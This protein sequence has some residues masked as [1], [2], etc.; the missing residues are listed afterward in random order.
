[1][2]HLI[3]TNA[4]LV[5]RA[6]YKCGRLKVR[7]LR[8]ETKIRTEK[9]VYAAIGWLAKERKIELSEEEGEVFVWL[10]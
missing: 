9:D 1:M 10:A 3:G 8:K 5:W 7:E 2:I 6:L 4:G